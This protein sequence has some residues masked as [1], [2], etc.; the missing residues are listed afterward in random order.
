MGFDCTDEGDISKLGVIGG[1]A[2]ILIQLWP[3]SIG[4]PEVLIQYVYSVP[5][6]SC[7][8]RDESQ[9][10]RGSVAIERR[11]LNQCDAHA[12]SFLGDRREQNPGSRVAL[13]LFVNRQRIRVSTASRPRIG[14]A[15]RSHPSLVFLQHRVGQS[16]SWL[17]IEDSHPLAAGARIA[18]RSGIFQ[19]SAQ[20]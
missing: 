15:R 9:P 11:H 14:N 16:R 3:Q 20:V 10:Y 12:P 13:R 6:I 5:D 19:L 17:E 7:G 2:E 4:T 1:S 8:L 18:S